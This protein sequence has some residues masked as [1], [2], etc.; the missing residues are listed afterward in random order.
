MTVSTVCRSSFSGSVVDVNADDGAL[1]IYIDDE[2]VN[3]FKGVAPA[4]ELS[5]M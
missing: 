5:S 1:V 3:H 4:R 2:A